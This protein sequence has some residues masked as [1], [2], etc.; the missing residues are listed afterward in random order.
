MAC[1]IS[2]VRRCGVPGRAKHPLAKHRRAKH[3]SVLAAA[4]LL[5]AA[6]VLVCADGAEAQR[7]HRIEGVRP[8]V[9]FSLGPGVGFGARFDIPIVPDG[10]LNGRIQDE[11]AL[12]PGFEF[13]FF[14]FDRRNDFDDDDFD[15]AFALPIVAQWNVFVHDKWS[16]FPEVG[17]TIIFT[18]R[19]WVYH[20]ED[21][22]D[23]LDVYADA[24]IG[25]GARYHFSDR[26]SLVFRLIY[27]FGFQFGVTF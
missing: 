21:F 11:L 7:P 17:F 14:D 15:F 8:E 9:H 2:S 12:S 19:D 22:D 26:G 18:D 5:A 20:A 4:S 3:R 10:F 23:D 27:P 13:Y 25:G 6:T 24:V 1:D 16:V